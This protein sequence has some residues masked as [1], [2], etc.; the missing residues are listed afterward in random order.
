M[1]SM[2]VLLISFGRVQKKEYF[3]TLETNN[4]LIHSFLITSTNESKTCLHLR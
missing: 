4:N 1:F 2:K 3:C